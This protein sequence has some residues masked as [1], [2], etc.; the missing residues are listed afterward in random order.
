MNEQLYGPDR[1]LAFLTR[2]STP[3]ASDS[4][5]TVWAL[6]ALMPVGAALLMGAH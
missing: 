4:T 2:A 6:L 5:L 1:S 3:N